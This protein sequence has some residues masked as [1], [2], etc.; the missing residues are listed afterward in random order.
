LSLR[1]GLDS[2]LRKDSENRRKNTPHSKAYHRFFEGYSE[3][4][5]PKAEGKGTR[6]ERIYT[7]DYYR[8]DL[9]N[10]QRILIRLLYVTLFLCAAY[11]YIS[12]AIVPLAINSTWYLVLPQAVS[13]PFLFWIIIAFFYYLPA[14][15]DMVIA[16][17]RRSSLSLQKATRGAAIA[18]GI[19]ALATLIYIGLNPSEG[20]LRVL[21][22]TIKYSVAGLITLAM[23]MIERKVKYL[24]IPSQHRPPENSYEIN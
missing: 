15:R 22:F 24:I 16:D 4:T 20:S 9:T 2:S 23:S 3:V 19:T 12:S 13:L 7:G 18:L 11:L 6:I 17:Y 10:L 8:Q 14:K 21:L 1:D 5:V